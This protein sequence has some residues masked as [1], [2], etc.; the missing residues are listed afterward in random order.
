MNRLSKFRTAELIEWARDDARVPKIGFAAVDEALDVVADLADLLDEAR[1]ALREYAPKCQANVRNRPNAR[2]NLSDE[3]L[4]DAPPPS[5]IAYTRHCG[6][7]A[8]RET[9]TGRYI[10]DEHKWID[11]NTLLEHSEALRKAGEK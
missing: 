3:P 4:P 6:A 10:C 2:V 7:P 9:R 8:T 5:E 11:P 1:A